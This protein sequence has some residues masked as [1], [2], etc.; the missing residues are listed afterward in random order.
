[1]RTFDTTQ[2]VWAHGKAPR[3]YGVWSFIYGDN[4]GPNEW[5]LR[6]HR[7]DMFG[8]TYGDAKKEIARTHPSIKEWQLLP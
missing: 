5:W 6:H 7:V 4:S 2:Y 8:M 1:M 3:G